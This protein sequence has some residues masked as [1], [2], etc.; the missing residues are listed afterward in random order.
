MKAVEALVLFL[1]WSTLVDMVLLS[2]ACENTT[3]ASMGSSCVEEGVEEGVGEGV[4]VGGLNR[5]NSAPN[6]TG[7]SPAAVPHPSL[8]L[9]GNHHAVRCCCA[10][11]V[12]CSSAVLTQ[13]P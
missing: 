3:P 11:G 2:C 8:P 12:A 7:L 13:P 10:H 1:T 5:F 4:E 9:V 6:S